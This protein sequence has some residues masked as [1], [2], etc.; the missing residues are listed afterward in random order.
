[1]RKSFLLLIGLLLLHISCTKKIENIVEVDDYVEH[2]KSKS[3]PEIKAQLI[4]DKKYIDTLIVESDFESV[5]SSHFSSGETKEVKKSV[6]EFSINYDNQSLEKVFNWY[7]DN[8]YFEQEFYTRVEEKD[9]GVSTI[10]YKSEYERVY[11]IEG[12]DTVFEELESEIDIEEMKYFHSGKEIKEN[13]IELKQIDSIYTK[14]KLDIPQALEKIVFNKNQKSIKHNAQL[15][16]VNKI[17][18]NTIEFEVPSEL[19]KKIIAVQAN[20]SKGFRMSSTA[21]SSNPIL[22]TDKGKI[23]VLNDL[24]SI[25]DKIL[26]ETDESKAKRFLNGI[27]QN[28][29]NVKNDLSEFREGIKKLFDDY[30]KE[31]DKDSFT[32]ASLHRNI[33][34]TGKKVLT[35]SKSS[36]EV[37]FLD[38]ID[39]IIIYLAKDIKSL[40]KVKYVK[41]LNNE[42]QASTC[43]INVFKE[44]DSKYNSKYGLVDKGGSI[45]VSANFEKLTPLGNYFF[46]E[47]EKLFWYDVKDKELV[48]LSEDY[49]Y[50]DDNIKP[51]YDIVGKKI[52]ENILYGILK[53]PDDVIIDFK[54][55]RISKYGNIIAASEENN[56]VFYDL[57]FKKLPV[58]G[59]TRIHQVGDELSSYLTFP[60]LFE[61]Q[62]KNYEIALLDKNLKPLTPFKYEFMKP[63]YNINN[64]YIVGARPKEN[65]SVYIC[66]IINDKGKEVVPLIFSD[67]QRD[68]DDAEILKFEINGKREKMNIREF[69]KKYSSR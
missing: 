45:L 22:E 25:Y 46:S 23:K 26:N 15:I 38:T 1:M 10:D 47:N 11:S 4:E 52:G 20:N 5:F 29:I 66:G 28:H 41:F 51:G 12:K 31:K 62:N 14:I 56:V 9:R 30:K 63:F 48:R 55:K 34:E 60:M 7:C 35:S 16:Q 64:Y 65:Q 19:N 49:V 33:V 32:E 43:P 57:N 54:Y 36:I 59:I 37:D 42:Y 27:K 24:K 13:K 68:D 69:I 8:L 58:T 3:L 67:I 44:F 18:G 21:Y 39:N 50:Y 61:A 2:L 6:D 17:K 53:T 40:R